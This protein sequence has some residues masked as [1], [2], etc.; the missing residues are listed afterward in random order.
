MICNEF[1]N[2]STNTKMQKW[3]VSIDRVSP[4]LGFFCAQFLRFPRVLEAATDCALQSV[5]R[6]GEC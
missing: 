3:N 5:Y 1:S 6:F 2:V 4:V